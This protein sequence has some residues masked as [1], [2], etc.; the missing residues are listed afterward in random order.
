M[1]FYKYHNLGNDF[2]ISKENVNNIELIKKICNRNIGIGADGLLIIK[3]LENLVVWI[4]NSDGSIATMCG[5][6]ICCFVAYLIDFCHLRKNKIVIN[7]IFNQVE[8][9]ILDFSNKKFKVNFGNPN[10]KISPKYLASERKVNIL[11]FDNVKYVLYSVYLTNFH[12]IVFV[13]D[14]KKIK[15]IGKA[16]STNPIFPNQC[17]IDFVKV[18]NKNCITV[19]T[20]ERGA[21]L[22]KSCGSGNCASACICFKLGLINKEVKINNELGECNVLLGEDV[23]L[24]AFA[25][26]VYEGNYDLK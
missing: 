18:D 6:G 13:N 24:I 19:K 17:N 3:D 23:Y 4:Y 26:Y 5:N 10:Y 7:T 22:T 21:Q 11:T 14:F 1:K 20:Y 2:I 8:V 9:E 12:C 16:F 25:T 15:A